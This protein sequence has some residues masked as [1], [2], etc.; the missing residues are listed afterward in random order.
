MLDEALALSLGIE[1][2]TLRNHLKG[3]DSAAGVTRIG[4]ACLIYLPLY[5]EHLLRTQAAN[6]NHGEH[7]A[8][9][10]RADRGVYSAEE[11]TS[12]ARVRDDFSAE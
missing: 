6:P 11:K 7:A 1:P 3:L 8:E 4:S 9:T 2:K 12:A 10:Y 5:Y